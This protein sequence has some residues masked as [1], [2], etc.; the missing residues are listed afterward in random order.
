MRDASAH[1]RRLPVLQREQRACTRCVEAGYIASAHP[2]FSGHA[3]QRVLLVGQAP[4]PVEI[5]HSR[6]FAGRAG[7]QLM[8]WLIRA[9][10]R[11]EDDVRDRI[12]MTAMTT[13]FPGRRADGAGDRRPS[14]AEVALCAPWL[15]AVL[16][17]LSPRLIIPIGSLAL[18][19]FLPG[20]RLDAVIGEAYTSGGAP[21]RGTPRAA[22]VLL[23]LPHP[24]GQ[25]RWLNDPAR[26]ALLDRAILRLGS[27][28]TWADAEH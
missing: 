1:T 24:S 7:R 8:R 5:D 10:F 28:I 25:S 26:M 27:L 11:D 13:C 17:L 14:A 16:A 2:V 19:R 9:G 20:R 23:P 18:E 21:C 3:G 15:D 6:P 22:P 12:Y 4:G